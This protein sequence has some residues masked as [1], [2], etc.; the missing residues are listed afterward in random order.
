[1]RKTLLKKRGLLETVQFPLH[2]ASLL[3]L[4]R[5][6]EGPT[7]VRGGS[8]CSRTCRS[9]GGLGIAGTDY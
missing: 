6:R 2:G 1:V 4:G 8:G 5:V 7:P 3:L 9:Q